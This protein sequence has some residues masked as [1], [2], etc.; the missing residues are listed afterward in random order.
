[1][2]PWERQILYT[3]KDCRQRNYCLFGVDV[4]SVGPGVSMECI[5]ETGIFTASPKPV[6]RRTASLITFVLIV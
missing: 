1:M 2:D 4:L 5:V 3:V 6:E